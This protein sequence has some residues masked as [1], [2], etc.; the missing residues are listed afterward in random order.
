MKKNK[1]KKILIIT[2]SRSDYD[3]LKPLFHEFE[4][5]KNL[6]LKILA[7]GSHFSKLHGFTYKKILSDKIKISKKINL[8]IISDKK[9]NL[10]KHLT[11][12][13]K[14]YFS[15]L[16]YIKPNLVIVLGDR[17]EI[18]SFSISSYIL[19]IPIAHIHG[20]EITRGAIDEG[21][22]HSITKMSQL[23]FVSH[24]EYKKRVIQLGEN[25]KNVFL[26]GSLEQENIL[27]TKT[28]KKKE[29]EKKLNIKFNKKNLMVSYH[30][31]TISKISVKSQLKELLL[32]IKHFSN[33]NFIFTSPNVDP[34][35]KEIIKSIKSFV[36]RNKNTFFTPS[37]GQDLFFSCIKYSDGMVGNSSSGIIELPVLRKG[38][39]NIGHRQEGRVRT[40]S[41]IDTACKKKNIILSV[42]KL[43]SKKFQTSL[44]N[45]NKIQSFKKS[46]SKSIVSIISNKIKKDINVDKK[47]FDLKF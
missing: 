18:F 2:G 30:P 45:K 41:I 3:L 34:G 7:T 36:K 9:N 22:R 17:Y 14:K 23:H 46:T 8:N 47:F 40:K 1:R 4:K 13:L 11:L 39:V 5:N 10:I 28:I 25:P 43:Y 38:T 6:K 31:E 20:G 26:V 24:S 21:F 15:Y 27:N 37:L 33:I 29:I 12:G 35:N 44:K 19:G 32:A 42:N 16:E